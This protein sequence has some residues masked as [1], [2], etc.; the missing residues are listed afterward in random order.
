[1]SR[2]ACGK[3][4]ARQFRLAQRRRACYTDGRNGEARAA[5]QESRTPAAV[6]KC[7]PYERSDKK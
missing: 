3:K 2:D 4:T 7:V 5:A 1:M 6:D